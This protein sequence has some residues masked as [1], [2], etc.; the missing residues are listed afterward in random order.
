MRDEQHGRLHLP[1]QPDEQILHVEAG[2]RIEGAERLV[3]EDDPRPEDERPGDRHPLAHPAG[4]FVGIL[5]GV[6]AR[7]EP[8]ALDPL[9][10]LRIARPLR[11]ALALKPEGD[12]PE[13]GAIVEA[14][15]IL[16]HH[17]PVG[18]GP[19]HLPAEDMDAPAGRGKLRLEARHHPQDRALAAARWAEEGRDLPLVGQVGD[20]EGDI[21]DCHRLARRPCVVDLCYAAELDRRRSAV[22]GRIDRNRPHGP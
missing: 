2:G 3:H 9:S 1:P 4:K 7:I 20:R 14:R 10:P 17:P 5:G 16:E 22:A 19:H 15:V 8:H 6:A 12:V 21:A 13:D 18:P 11:H